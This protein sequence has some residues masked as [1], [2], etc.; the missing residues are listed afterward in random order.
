MSARPE[1]RFATLAGHSVHYHDIGQGEPVVF[2]HGGG[3]GASSWSNFKGNYRR[4]VDEGFRTILMDAVGF[5]GSS[6]PEDIAYPIDLH[7]QTVIELLDHLGVRAATLVGNSMGGATA[8]KTALDHSD[9]VSR[10]ILLAPGGLAPRERY[11]E[12]VGIRTMVMAVIGESGPTPENLRETFALQ[13]FDQTLI[14]EALIE[15]RYRVALEQPRAI[16]TTAAIPDMSGEL[17][18]ITCPVLGFW[19]A[20]DNFC[21][22]EHAG[23]LAQGP[24]DSRVVSVNRCGH[25]VQV[26]HPVLFDEMSAAFLKGRL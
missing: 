14:T 9:R 22:F 12:M 25:W 6:K 19:G 10:L 16:Y 18:R 3:P 20:N 1:S 5:G 15:E 4:F 7:V 24:L 21:P 26:E 11:G 8:I 23:L 17:S 13:L 2:L